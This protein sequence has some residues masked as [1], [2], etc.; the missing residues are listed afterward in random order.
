MEIDCEP[1]IHLALCPWACLWSRVFQ[2]HIVRSHSEVASTTRLGEWGGVSRVCYSKL[3]WQ[4]GRQQRSLCETVVSVSYV[5]VGSPHGRYLGKEDR[6]MRR[7]RACWKLLANTVHAISGCL[8]PCLCM[9]CRSRTLCNPGRSSSGWWDSANGMLT[10]LH[11]FSWDVKM[12]SSQLRKGTN[13]PKKGFCEPEFIWVS[14]Q[15]RG[16]LLW[17]HHQEFP[18]WSSVYLFSGCWEGRVSP[19]SCDQLSRRECYW[20]GE[21]KNS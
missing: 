2:N 18:P 11:S 12:D 8:W 19:E 6:W 14:L 3:R 21:M 10:V 15:E 1:P 16:S 4:C 17:L 13:R 9:A 7:A 20:L 5:G